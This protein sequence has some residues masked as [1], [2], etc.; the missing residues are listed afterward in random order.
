MNQTKSGTFRDFLEFFPEIELPITL[1][2]EIHHLFSSQNKPIH[3]L[4]IE[5]FILPLEGPQ[6]GLNEFIAC[7]KIPETHQFHAIVYWAA[8]I[9]GYTY[10]L[11]TFTKEGHLIDNKVIAGTFFDGNQ[12]TQSIATI[13]PDWEIF[14][15]TGQSG[16]TID[17][18]NPSQSKAFQLE[19]LPDGYISQP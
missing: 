1:N 2:D 9:T 6:D 17:Q 13:D 11:V 7:F 19:L 14:V 3:P 16:Q 4:L 18:F 12:L 8:G 5:K 15:A 10:K